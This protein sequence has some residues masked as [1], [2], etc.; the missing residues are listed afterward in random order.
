[1]NKWLWN[2][3][4][5]KIVK[6]LITLAVAFLAAP[7]TTSALGNAGVTVTVDPSIA[8]GAVYGVL[9]LIRNFIGTKFGL[10]WM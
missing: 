4:A 9:E 6:R 8:T 10:K 5:G 2:I 7:A 3:A 1:M